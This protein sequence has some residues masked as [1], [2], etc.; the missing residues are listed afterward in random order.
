MDFVFLSQFYNSKPQLILAECKTNKEITEEDTQKLKFVADSLPKDKIDVFIL[1]SK[2]SP[3][4]QNEIKYCGNIRDKYNFRVIMLTDRELEPYN[5]YEKTEKSFDV[6]RI[7]IEIE[8][9]AE[10]TDRI[11]F[12]PNLSN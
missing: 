10:A 12:N 11:Y 5:I 6:P 3:F 1:F 4:T 8:K 7:V 2:L 9:L